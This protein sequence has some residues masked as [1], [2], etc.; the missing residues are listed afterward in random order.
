MVSGHLRGAGQREPL[1]TPLPDTTA[2]HQHELSGFV[3]SLL[4]F[5]QAGLTHLGLTESRISF[6]VKFQQIKPG[7]KYNCFDDF[8]GGN[9][10]SL[11]DRDVF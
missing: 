11:S 5:V 10:E 8:E 4:D 9:Q 7:V 6:F 3:Q 2:H 1:L